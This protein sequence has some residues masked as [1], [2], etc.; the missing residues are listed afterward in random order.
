MSPK[1]TG[2]EPHIRA[3][4]KTLIG[5]GC[6]EYGGKIRK[7]GYGSVW[8]QNGTKEGTTA[9]AH[10][11]VYEGMVGPI[12]EG[13][14]LCHHCD[15]PKCVRPD[16]IFVGTDADNKAD[17][18]AKGR[19]PHGETHWKSKVTHC[20]QGHPYSGDNLYIRNCGRRMCRACNNARRK[21][22]HQRAKSAA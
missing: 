18:Y 19:H 21:K 16:H 7:D 15:N 5:E 4:D 8:I 6:W 11:V 2:V 10:R 13:M 3:L 12:P 9:L 17:M 20:P 14:Y 22:S 1:G